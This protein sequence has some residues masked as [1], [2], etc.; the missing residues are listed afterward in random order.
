MLTCIVCYS[1]YFRSLE[2]HLTTSKGPIPVIVKYNAGSIRARLKVSPDAS[3]IDVLAPR[4]MKQSE[5]EEFIYGALSWVEKQLENK[6]TAIPYA[7]GNEIPV[8]DQNFTIG[9]END[10]RAW[11][12]LDIKTSKLMIRGFDKVIVPNMCQ[13]YLFYHLYEYIEKV[14]NDYS[15][16][17]GVSFNKIAIRNTRSRWGSCSVQGNLSF[18]SKLVHA[19]MEKVN[20]VI[21]HEI[22]HLKEMNHSPNF[23][24]LVKSLDPNY[25]QNR[26][27][28]RENAKYIAGIGY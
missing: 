28:L 3:F 4:F 17:L 20:Y 22:S 10:I 14:A 23:W 13:Q 26:F 12:E 24:A 8:F 6:V 19:P 9:F 5:L 2:M 18:A 25:M 27:W 11:V 1:K 16:K 7:V 21:A 15:Q